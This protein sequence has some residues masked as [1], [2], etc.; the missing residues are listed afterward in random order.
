MMDEHKPTAIY[1]AALRHLSPEDWADYGVND[2]AYLK[3]VTLEGEARY[4]IHA[5]NGAP[6]A[7]MDSRE[8]AQAAIMQNELEAVS[9]H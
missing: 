1:I 8:V 2:V 4:A 7:V 3:P 9:V 5:A 6:L